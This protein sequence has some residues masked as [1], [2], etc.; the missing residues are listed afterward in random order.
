MAQLPCACYR[1]KQCHSPKCRPGPGLSW[2]SD[3][4]P[5]DEAGGLCDSV[6]RMQACAAVVRQ[7]IVSTL[8]YPVVEEALSFSVRFV[9]EEQVKDVVW[10]C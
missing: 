8:L 1:F 2:W 7:V 10:D 5:N 6:Y 3:L 4:Y 9:R